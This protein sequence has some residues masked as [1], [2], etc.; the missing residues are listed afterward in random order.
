MNKLGFSRL[1]ISGYPS[2]CEVNRI[3]VFYSHKPCGEHRASGMFQ[4][5]MIFV[6]TT[7]YLSHFTL[8]KSKPHCRSFTLVICA[9]KGLPKPVLSKESVLLNISRL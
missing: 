5:R 6:L 4:S 2:L 7:N 8:T 1:K 3:D 9:V